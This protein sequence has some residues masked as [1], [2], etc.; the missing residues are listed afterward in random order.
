MHFNSFSRRCLYI[1]AFCYISNRRF[2]V[3]CLLFDTLK[4]KNFREINFEQIVFVKNVFGRIFTK[5]WM[6]MQKFLATNKLYIFSLFSV[7]TFLGRSRSAWS[8]IATC[9][10]GLLL[11]MMRMVAKMDFVQKTI[12]F[13]TS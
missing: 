13:F 5:F 1:S 3:L 11:V 12:V 9:D 6:F 7:Y 4:A 8:K 2:C 10:Q